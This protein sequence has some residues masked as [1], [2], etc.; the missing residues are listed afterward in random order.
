MAA[1]SN[2]LQPL[3]LAER[4]IQLLE[5][6]RFSATYKYA[7]LVALMDLCLEKTGEQ[8]SPPTVLTTHEL[9][10][11]VISLYWPQ[12][13]PYSPGHRDEGR[14]LS[15]GGSQKVQAEILRLIMDFKGIAQL[16]P[17]A[18]LSLHRARAHA[19]DAWRT[20]LHEV[21]W[22]LIEMP[23]PR[24]QFVGQDEDRFLYQ[25][26]WQLEERSGGERVSV[27]RREVR[28]Y[29]LGKSSPFDNRIHLKPGV[30]E[31]LVQLSGVLRPLIH[32][33]WAMMVA[34]VN[35]M[36]ESRLEQFLFGMD[37]IPLQPVQQ[38]L[39]Q[40]QQRRCFYCR[41]PLRSEVQIDHF[42]PWARHPDNAIE[43]LVATHAA[44]NQNKRDFLASVEHV[45]HW[46][47]RLEQ[48]QDALQALAQ[49]ASW[50]S[51]QNRVLSVARAI[52]YP[53]PPQ[54]RLWH[55]RE[56]FVPFEK[57]RVQHILRKK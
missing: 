25:I 51:Q 8:G 49:K 3:Q 46:H 4:I 56:L 55:A 38:G 23:L 48:E 41:E 7:V 40:L 37:R 20:L 21:E 36:E 18:S 9:A 24:L 10:E 28:A 57:E 13:M 22:K 32:R 44:C 5:Q 26:G 14:L 50:E 54:T 45:S 43:N 16:N 34:Q 33:Q 30:A 27:R 2:S 15:Q 12:C 42:I 29:Q 53:L 47:A 6:G 35:D 39:I 17:A 31:Q 1:D 52:Y 19:P 11:K